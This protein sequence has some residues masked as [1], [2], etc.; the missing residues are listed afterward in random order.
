MPRN[1]VNQFKRLNISAIDGNNCNK[2]VDVKQKAKGNEFKI[3]FFLL[4]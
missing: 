3:H 2:F 4:M 1:K